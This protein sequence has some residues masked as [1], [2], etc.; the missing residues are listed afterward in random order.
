[1]D[2]DMLRH[3][4]VIGSDS[5]DLLR[6]HGGAVIVDLQPVFDGTVVGVSP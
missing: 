5:R 3:R 2:C 1:M 4:E 6:D